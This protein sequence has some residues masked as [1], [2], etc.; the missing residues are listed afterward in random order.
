VR[1]IGG[2]LKGRTINA[3]GNLPARPTTD[4]AKTGLFNILN[5]LVDF[6]GLHVLDLFG[7]T[8]NITLEF[9]SR[10]AEKVTYV[11]KDFR[12]ISFMKKETERLELNEVQVVRSDVYVFLRSHSEKYD[13][14]FADP[15]YDKGDAE[16]MHAE[17]FGRGLLKESGL[18]II[19][20]SERQSME[21][22][23]HFRQERK[24]G[25]VRFSFFSYPAADALPQKD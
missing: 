14:I 24:Y 15:P 10:G 2:R 5:N 23:S 21:N 3:P 8:G 11:E 17:I 22:F 25:N 13:L 20:H 9:A 6:E 19:E 16:K 12:C 18:L 4:F 7:G 1:I